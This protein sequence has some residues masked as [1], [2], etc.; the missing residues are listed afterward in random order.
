MS[1]HSQAAFAVPAQAPVTYPA[2]IPAPAHLAEFPELDPTQFW[3]DEGPIVFTPEEIRASQKAMI[4]LFDHWGL[5]AEQSAILLGGI[6]PRTFQ[7]WKKGE[8]GRV[9][10]DTALR[11]SH[12]LGV[13]HALWV[14][15]EESDRHF[16]WVKRPNTKFG[17]RTAL[18]VMLDGGFDS[19][20]R[21]RRYL[22][23]ET[24]IW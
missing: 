23:A 2:P 4:S 19:I 14:I 3:G 12:L 24:M 22:D 1:D 20:V 17:G 11:M 9:S 8:Y 15:F 6:S 18:D 7:R 21:M 16:G 5:T 10:H 13:H